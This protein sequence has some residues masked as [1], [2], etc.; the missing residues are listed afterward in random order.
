LLTLT[1]TTQPKVKQTSKVC[2]LFTLSLWKFIC[3]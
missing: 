3:I 2:A 1:V